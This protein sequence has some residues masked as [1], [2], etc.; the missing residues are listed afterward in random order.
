MVIAT[1]VDVTGSAYRR[2]G[3]HLLLVDDGSKAGSISA[4]CLENDILA[5]GDEVFSLSRALLLEYESDEFFGLN[6]GCDGTIHVLIQPVTGVETSY[7]AAFKRAQSTGRTFALATVFSS[8]DEREIGAQILLDENDMFTSSASASV[9]AA[10]ANAFKFV[11]SSGAS[12]SLQL[13]D[14]N[15]KVFF[16]VIKPT[17]R[18]AIFGAGEDA[19]SLISCARSIGMDSLL[20]DSRLS[21]LERFRGT[22]MVHHYDETFEMGAIFDAPDRTAI[23]IMSHNFELDKRFLATAL[24]SNCAYIGVM[25]SHKRT[26]KILSEIGSPESAIRIRFPIGLDLGADSPEEIALSI[27]SEILAFFRNGSGK[28]LSASEGPIH[29]RVGGKGEEV[30]RSHANSKTSRISTCRYS[31]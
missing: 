2:P 13:E 12:R 16:E 19:V 14:G 23:V 4:G 28:P 3:A 18:L 8:D 25:G 26:T 30:A 11:M 15:A 29:H 6:Y 10:V 21:Y 22:E 27:C 24:E 31:T 1:V 5:R 7:P 20:I 17:P 9:A